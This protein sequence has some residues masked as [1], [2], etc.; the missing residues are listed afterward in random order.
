MLTICLLPCLAS[1]CIAGL[2][3]NDFSPADQGSDSGASSAPVTPTFD[4]PRLSGIVIDGKGSSW[5]D[6]G[7]VVKP[8]FQVDDPIP[9]GH[10]FS[11][12]LRL[13]WDDR[14]LLVLANVTD[15]DAEEADD[16]DPLYGK[17]C[18]EFYLAPSRSSSDFVHYVV[19]PGIDPKHPQ[20]RTQSIDGRVTRSLRKAPI[21]I[22][23]KSSKTAEGYIIEAR[24]PWSGLGIQP[25]LGTTLAL[26]ISANDTTGKTHTRLIWFPQD[27]AWADAQ[28]MNA[29]RLAVEPSPSP[30]AVAAAGIVDGKL[31]LNVFAVPELAGATVEAQAG[32]NV[33]G[34]ATLTLHGGRATAAIQLPEG[35]ETKPNS[36]VAVLANGEA[37]WTAILPDYLRDA[38]R[39]LG[40]SRMTV[41][42]P[43]FS[44][45]KFPTVDFE[46][47]D[48]V[49]AQFGA[50]S[51]RTTYFDS[52]GKQVETA[53]RPGR[54]G[55]L[56]EVSVD[57]SHKFYREFE[58]FRA[59]APVNW[60]R[61]A[62]ESKKE[63]LVGLGIA[64]RLA[65][66]DTNPDNA[67]NSLNVASEAAE[68]Y[69]A[70]SADD[71]KDL[72]FQSF[73]YR[74][75]LRRKAGASTIYNAIVSLPEDYE[76]STAPAPL[77]LFLHGSGER[78]DDIEMVS[79]QGPQVQRA[80]GKKLPFIIVSPQCPY[81]EWWNPKA[82]MVLLDE[83]EAKYRV[84]ESRVYVTGL[85]MGGFGTWELATD[86]PE[87]FA[88]VAPIAGGGDPQRV[89]RMKGVPVWAFHGAL[90]DV[91]PI[92]G[93]Q[94]TVD[95]LKAAGGDVRFTVYPDR[96]HDSWLPAYD[97]LRLY[98]WLLRHRLRAVPGKS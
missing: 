35:P 16:P 31:V 9:E 91:V 72:Q 67:R 77:L 10:H 94:A 50:Y 46:R 85:S 88:A 52:D 7:L 78:G 13:G 74:Y 23:A 98:K 11:A 69:V 29:L 15:P 60:L 38:I 26:Q 58:L 44:G 64:P 70:K 97:D 95:A 36:A 90:D 2:H 48:N 14:G 30:K 57:P 34:S 89:A 8:L 86:H 42:E 53:D 24:I 87:R 93:D 61:A 71:V 65:E 92:S 27:G 62:K 25:S 68:L 28:A 20:L 6:R 47:P 96:H 32:G 51:I 75:E 66:S 12:T 5:G 37:L 81:G 49:K 45:S 76:K 22:E 41:S 80:A 56:S 39:G 54:Y 43:I 19:A 21:R 84:D 4:V 1:V 63:F 40:D 3:D 79:N 18:I 59:P 83:V 82:L 33:L 55:A 17:D 73:L